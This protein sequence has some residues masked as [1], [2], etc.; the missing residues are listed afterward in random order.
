MLCIFFPE[1]NKGIG[2]VFSMY[3]HPQQAKEDNYQPE[4]S[5]F[6]QKMLLIF[7][8]NVGNTWGIKN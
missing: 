2:V 6:W 4:A 3:L 7:M 5:W 8:H 1:E